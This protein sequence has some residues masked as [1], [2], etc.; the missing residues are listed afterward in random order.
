LKTIFNQ[1]LER[2]GF[3]EGVIWNRVSFDANETI[4]KEGESSGCVYLLL[5]GSARVVASISLGGE[6]LLHPGF[7]DLEEGEVFGELSLLDNEPHSTSVVAIDECEIAVIK[8]TLFIDYLD[9]NPADGQ[10][11]FKLLSKTLVERLRKTN[12]K[13]F[14]LYAWGLKVHGLGEHL[15]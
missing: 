11:V 1:L 13:A 10:E 4:I 2:P 8:N 3:E 9:Q 12:D 14:S 15:K 6:H 5:N 7:R